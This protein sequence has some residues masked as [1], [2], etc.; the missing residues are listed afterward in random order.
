MK[1]TILYLDDEEAN[2]RVFKSV[3]RRDFH[4]L[5]ALTGEEGLKL[6]DENI[7]HLI[8]TDQRMPGMTGVE[9]L[10]KVYE[11]IPSIPPNRMILSG[12]SQTSDIDVAREKYF[13]YMFVSKP[14]DADDLKEKIED[15]ITNAYG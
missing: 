7:C 1:H 8:I 12:F 14:W 3:F 2:L 10:Q 5:T 15:A 9:F 11:K 13:L 4:I 6:L